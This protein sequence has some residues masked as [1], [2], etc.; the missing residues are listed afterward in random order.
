RN[1]G[2]WFDLFTTPASSLSAVATESQPPSLPLP[3]DT[4]T[5]VLDS[6]MASQQR[7]LLQGDRLAKELAA[8]QA[9]AA[10]RAY[11]TDKGCMN[12]SVTERVL[13]RGTYSGAEA[14][15]LAIA[16]GGGLSVHKDNTL[17]ILRERE[18]GRQRQAKDAQK[19]ANLKAK[20]LQQQENFRKEKATGKGDVEG[21]GSV[22][23]DSTP[24]PAGWEAVMD[25]QGSGDYYYWHAGTNVTTWERPSSQ[26]PTAVPSGDTGVPTLK[27]HNP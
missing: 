23:R 16:A 24:L 4:Q 10:A 2:L 27:N 6:A 21:Q 7:A 17:E 18:L 20:L 5:T 13:N 11:V 14:E 12:V 22:E 15:E 8:Q 1:A 19:E 3:A 26:I 25:P 9:R